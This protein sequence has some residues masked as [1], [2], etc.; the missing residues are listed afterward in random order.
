MLWQ[1]FACARPS[2]LHLST[3]ARVQLL[4]VFFPKTSEYERR[5]LALAVPPSVAAV[6]G[7]YGYLQ[8]DLLRDIFD[9]HLP[10][11]REDYVKAAAEAVRQ[12]LGALGLGDHCAADGRGAHFDAL[13]VDGD[14]RVRAAAGVLCVALAC[15]CT[16]RWLHKSHRC[17]CL[18]PACSLTSDRLFRPR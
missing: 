2:R 5:K 12:L 13:D 14:G 18:D 6:P 16:A 1:R 8:L 10:R 15:A 9:A 11:G 17:P 4:K 7:L 3:A